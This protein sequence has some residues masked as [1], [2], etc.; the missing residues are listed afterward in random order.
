MQLARTFT[1]VWPL[2]FLACAGRAPDPV[3]PTFPATEFSESN[4]QMP[5]WPVVGGAEPILLS[6]EPG[7]SGSDEQA[8]QEWR[9]DASHEDRFFVALADAPSAGRPADRVRLLRLDGAMCEASVARPV[10]VRLAGFSRTDDTSGRLRDDHEMLDIVRSSGELRMGFALSGCSGDYRWAVPMTVMPRVYFASRV[11][12]LGRLL[13]I[14]SSS[15]VWRST[16]ESYRAYMRQG[17]P[18]I[19]DGPASFWENGASLVVYD[20]EGAP[21]QHFTL[22]DAGLHG[23]GAHGFSALYVEEDRRQGITSVGPPDENLALAQDYPLIDF[24]RDGTPEVM[25]EESILRLENGTWVFWRS[26]SYVH[27]RCSC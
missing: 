21:G 14:A 26:L 17:H 16:Q 19:A 7:V 4:P 22:V 20:S 10:W 11:S 5:V 24:D 6:D 9:L 23:C 13:P 2:A 27:D 18:W 3:A 25:Q 12:G 8:A 15:A 1:L